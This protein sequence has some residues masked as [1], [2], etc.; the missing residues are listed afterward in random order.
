MRTPARNPGASHL[1]AMPS[2]SVQTLLPLAHTLRARGVDVERVLAQAGLQAEQL[3][4]PELRIPIAQS[5]AVWQAAYQLAGDPALGLHV[6]E[7]IEAGAHSLFTYLS[8]T[9]AT[10][11]EAH[12]RAVRYL[13]IAHDAVEIELSVEG[14]QSICRSGLRGFA[15]TRSEAEYA[16]GLMVKLAPRVSGKLDLEVWFEHE[17]PDYRDEYVRVLRCPVRFGAPCDALVGKTADLDRPLPSADSELCALIEAHAQEQLAKLPPVGTFADRVGQ[18]I[19]AALP[20]G[21]PSAEAVAESLGMSARTLR[22]RL[23]QCG[24]SHQR[25]L[26]DVRC[27]LARRTL[28]QRG[29]S[30][31]EVAYLLGFSDTSAFHKAFRR[32]TGRTPAEYLRE[33]RARG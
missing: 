28:G 7:Q 6:V 26:D 33:V 3:R 14:D 29:V 4:D 2:C 9:S 20:D 15:R 8:A 13:R 1:E 16:V 27:E 12:A 31:N 25:L 10:G 30:V 11:R 21:N 22:R 5:H 17:A 18:R 19:A 24:T 23:E 32:W